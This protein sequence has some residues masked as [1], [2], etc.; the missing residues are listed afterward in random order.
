MTSNKFDVDE[1]KLAAIFSFDGIK[2]SNGRKF[3][4]WTFKSYVIV[5]P[6]GNNYL[7]VMDLTEQYAP[8]NKDVVLLDLNQ[9]VVDIIGTADIILKN[10]FN[11]KE[12]SRKEILEKMDSSDLYFRDAERRKK[13]S[14]VK[15][16]KK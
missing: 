8:M 5:V 11:Q 6:E 13:S 10:K 7:N 4:S 14:F 16:L 15:I 1:L 12:F 2:N 9:E 3:K